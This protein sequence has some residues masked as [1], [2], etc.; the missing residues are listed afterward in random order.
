MP[1]QA[2]PSG[3]APWS[4]AQDGNHGG[5]HDVQR[6]PQ[7]DHHPGEAPIVHPSGKAEASNP[8]LSRRRP[9][10]DLSLEGREAALFIFNE[11]F[12][13]AARLR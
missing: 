5:E 9:R 4:G 10:S 1:A 2:A 8:L 7:H 6:S 12:G 11:G 13:A 3:M